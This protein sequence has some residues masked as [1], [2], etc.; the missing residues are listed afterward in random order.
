MTAD[1]SEHAHVLFN[2]VLTQRRSAEAARWLAA[3]GPP[4]AAGNPQRGPSW[5]EHYVCISTFV[6]DAV[7]VYKRTQLARGA[8]ARLKHWPAPARVQTAT[9]LADPAIQGPYQVI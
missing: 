6:V 4:G 7:R 5:P 8:A 3:C 1:T 9:V 2:G